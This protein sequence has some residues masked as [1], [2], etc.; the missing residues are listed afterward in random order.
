MA[1]SFDKHQLGNLEYSLQREI[2]ATNRAGG[3][4]STTIVCCNTRKYHG[5]MVCPV[6]ELEDR[7]YV[8]LSSLDETIIQH[9]QS[10]NL[11]IHRYKDN[12]EPKGHKYITDFWYAPTP[13][14]TYRVGGVILKKELLWVHSSE[15]LLVRYTLEQAT[16]KTLLRLRP[17]LAFR[18]R[19][20]LSKAN[21][22]ADVHSYEAPNGVMNKLYRGLPQLW[23]QTSKKAKFIAAPDWYYGFEYPVEAA[24]G[25]EAYEDLLT[26]G[27]FELE[28]KA[29]ESVIFSASTSEV[30]PRALSSLFEKEIAR[31]SEK[32]DFITAMSHSARQFL[33]E[34]QGNAMLQAGYPWYNPR[35]RETFVALA[36]C[37]LSQGYVEACMDILKYHTS[38]LR[39]GIFGSHLAADTQLWFFHSL[40][41]LE[42]AVGAEAIWA[43]F[44]DAMKEILYTYK[45][46]KTPEGCIRMEYNSLVWAHKAGAALTWMK[47]TVNGVPVTQRP[48]F[49]VEVNALWYNAICYAVELAA[50]AGDD[51]FVEEWE[52]IAASVKDNFVKVFWCEKHN[53]LADYVMGEYKNFDVR[54]NQ[55]LAVSLKYSPLQDTQKGKVLDIV[56]RHLLT[57]RGVRTL[58]PFSVN[59]IGRYGGTQAERS[60]AAYQGTVVPWLL[61]HYVKARFELSGKSFLV[62][63]EDLLNNFREDLTLYGVGSMPEFYDGDP[64]HRPGGAISFAPSVSMVLRV[65]KMIEENS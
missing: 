37:L 47:G 26:T 1:L 29:G 5:L 57:S 8:L 30:K 48:G 7:E 25:E 28:L 22:E 13:T 33:I 6:N 58:S 59:Y 54:P 4:M 35:S 19:H 61:G 52:K 42:C 63:A 55:L 34:Y 49:A 44:G 51:K 46:G 43:N 60:T 41:Q 64:A 24:R 18:D 38:R 21:M 31:R 10:F 20:A 27:Y 62:E 16:S 15:Q 3:Y 12:Y 14:I 23:M 65:Q 17:F 40:T 45:D 39:G 56:Q 32:K 11:A 50:K 2:L 53:Y 9:D 36:G